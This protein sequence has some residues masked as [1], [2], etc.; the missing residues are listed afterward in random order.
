MKQVPASRWWSTLMQARKAALA[1]LLALSCLWAMPVVSAETTSVPEWPTSAEP[2]KGQWTNMVSSSF[3][4]TLPDLMRQCHADVQAFPGQLSGSDCQRLFKLEEA[5]DYY[6]QGQVP[7]GIILDLLNGLHRG[8]SH[9]FLGRQ[10]QLGRQAT[11]KVFDLGG[12]LFAYWFTGDKG[13]SCNNLAWVFPPESAAAVIPPPPAA[14]PTEAAVASSTPPT[15]EARWVCHQ[16]PT[17]SRPVIGG[18]DH[19]TLPGINLPN[20][21]QVHGVVPS[22]PGLHFHAQTEIQSSSSMQVCGWE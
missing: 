2:P 7:D 11:A 1:A 17:H 12:G 15:R 5:R 16:V 8:E 14:P 20:C 21:G 9:D 3:G 18:H 4:G 13:V 22:V 19:F 6:R 10:K